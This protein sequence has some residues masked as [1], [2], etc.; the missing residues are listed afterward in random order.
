L[1]IALVNVLPEYLSQNPN[2]SGGHSFLL[3]SLLAAHYTF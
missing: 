1:Q 3:A 2:V